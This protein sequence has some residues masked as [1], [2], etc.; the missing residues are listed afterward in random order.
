[1]KN[2]YYIFYSE[3][4]ANRWR[5]DVVRLTLAYSWVKG[6]NTSLSTLNTLDERQ[7][8]RDNIFL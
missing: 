8:D 6:E 4:A 1:M 5:Y 3:I 7:V 2:K